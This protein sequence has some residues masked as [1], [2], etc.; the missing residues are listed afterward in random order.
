MSTTQ[1]TPKSAARRMAAGAVRDGYAPQALHTYTDSDGQPL[2]WRI[3]AKNAAGDK[4]IRP[5][6]LTGTGYVLSEPAA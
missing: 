2:Y 6:K 4:W 1:E 5:M 3:R